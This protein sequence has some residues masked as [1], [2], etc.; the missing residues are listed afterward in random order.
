MAAGDLYAAARELLEA[1]QAAL[2]LEGAPVDRAFV[3]PALPALDCC[4]QLTVHIGGAA[5][6]DTAPLQPPLQPGHRTPQV[7]VVPLVQLT[8]TIVRCSPVQDAGGN[9]PAASAIDATAEATAADLWAIWNHLRTL[10][11][12]GLLFTAPAGPPGREMYFDPAFPLNTAGGC[13]G[14]QIPLRVSLGGY[15]T[16]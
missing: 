8:V 7:G 5:E 15:S 14:W 6:G 2:V 12:E 1:T 13:A 11:R 3:S 16:S 10:H 4:P 9:P